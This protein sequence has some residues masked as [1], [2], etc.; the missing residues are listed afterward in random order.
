MKTRAYVTRFARIIS[1]F[2]LP[3]KYKVVKEVR[4]KIN[5][6]SCGPAT[7]KLYVDV[8]S[9]GIS[10]RNNFGELLVYPVREADVYIISINGKSEICGSNQKMYKTLVKKE[11]LSPSEETQALFKEYTMLNFHEI[12]KHIRDSQIRQVTADETFINH[13][14]VYVLKTSTPLNFFSFI[15]CCFEDK[16]FIEA[17]FKTDSLNSR[18]LEEFD[19]AKLRQFSGGFNIPSE[20]LE[21]VFEDIDF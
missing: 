15:P 7:R 19:K 16:T 1:N 6:Q 14:D 4:K 3:D 2:K 17:F 10:C 13:S 12:S 5:Q 8:L 20:V 11:F 18:L 9:V 21:E